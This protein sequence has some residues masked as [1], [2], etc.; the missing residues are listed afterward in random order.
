MYYVRES[1]NDL[2]TLQRTSGDLTQCVA[3]ANT[4]LV[5]LSTDQDR[6]LAVCRLETF[7]TEVRL[8]ITAGSVNINIDVTYKFEFFEDTEGGADYSPEMR[9]NRILITLGAVLRVGPLWL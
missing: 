4:P 5:A 9:Q 7:Q 8:R 3:D 1:I 6:A 2:V